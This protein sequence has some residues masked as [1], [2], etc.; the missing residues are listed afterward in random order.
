MAV[1]KV[2]DLRKRYKEIEAVRGISFEV[3]KGEIFGFLGPNGAGKTTTLNIITCMAS[4]S[5][6]MVKLGGI[7]VSVNPSGAKRKMGVVP[8]F[9]SLDDDL[10]ARENLLVYARYF[11][12]PKRQRERRADELLRLVELERWADKNL[13]TFSGGMLQRL[14]IVRS[15]ITNPRVLVLD[16]PTIGLDPQARRFVWELLR[17]LNKKGMPI[18]MTTHYMDEA[19]KLCDRIAVIDY[20]RILAL[21]TPKNLLKLVHAK[22]SVTFT[23]KKVPAKLRGVLGR[24]KKVGEFLVHKHNSGEE[25]VV[26]TGHSLLDCLELV[27]KHVNVLS[28]TMREPTLEDVFIHLTGR[29]MRE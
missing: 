2:E 23:V 28:V 19:E 12:V 17:K 13:Y 21:D 4:K 20:G 8:Q 5:S 25:L 26:F 22:R 29:E 10:T 15:L 24:D 7:D 14:L 16:E 27:R 1:I 6:G 18:L 3:K 11:G 9:L